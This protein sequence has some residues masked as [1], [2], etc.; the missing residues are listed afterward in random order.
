MLLNIGLLPAGKSI[1]VTFNVTVNNP[2]QGATNTV[3]NQGSVTGTNFGPVLTDD[4][5]V[6]GAADPTV[7]PIDQPNVTVAVAPASVLEDGAGNLV[8]TF[9]REG[10]TAA[11][12]TVNFSVGGTATFNTDYTQTGAATFNATS[13]TVVIPIG[14]STATVTLD[15][16]ADITVEGNETA[17]LTVISGTSYDVGTPASASG[18]ITNDDTDVTVA[19]SPSSVEEDGAPNLVYTFTRNGVT[20]GALTVN[21]TINGTATFNDDY[22]QTGAATFTPPNGTVIFADGSSTATVTVN[23][24]TDNTVEPNETVILTLAAGTGYNVANPSTATGT[25]TNDDAEVT[26][27][28]APSSVDEDGIPNLVYTF[29]RTGDTTGALVVNFTIGGTATFNTD[30]TQIGATTFTPPNGTVPSAPAT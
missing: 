21:F 5:S 20:A 9:T 30:Y 14:S 23:P 8:Y 6:G 19:V 28:V 1:T 2:W 29:T 24:T 27:A 3:S 7:T 25:I 17:V 26:L 10:S 15:P 16:A 18:T 4:P 11:A 22:T 13:G 12:L